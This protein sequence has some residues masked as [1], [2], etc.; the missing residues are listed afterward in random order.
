MRTDEMRRSENVEDRRGMRTAGMPVGKM[1]GGGIGVLLIA[2]IAMVMGADPTA[3]LGL[4]GGG[5]TVDAQ[6]PDAR[7]RSPAED[8]AADFVSRVLGS[9]EDVWQKQMPRLG[10]N[11]AEPRL[12]LF[13]DVANSACGRQGAAVGPFYCPGDSKVYLDLSFFEQLDRELGAPGDFAQAYVVAHE[14]GHHVQNLVG[15]SR[16]VHEQQSSLD[17]V[18]ADGLSVRMELQADF[19]AGVWAHY[20]QQAGVLDSG[21]LDEAFRAASKIGDDVLQ[22]RA[23]GQVTPDSFTHGTAEQRMRWFKRGFETGDPTQGDTFGARQ[24]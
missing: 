17:E 24:L 20:A 16:Q 8:R 11:Y 14:I 2:V 10:R 5:E 6:I 22:R 9:T 13:T 23:R 21:D 4:N 15:T 7:P 1:A 18:G 12:Q 19:Y 3:L